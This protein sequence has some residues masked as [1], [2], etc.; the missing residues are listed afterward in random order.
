[1]RNSRSCG[2]PG[3]VPPGVTGPQSHARITC[4]HHR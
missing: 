1:V 3:P 2:G 4:R